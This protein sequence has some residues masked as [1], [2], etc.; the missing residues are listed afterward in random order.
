M[1][2]LIEKR[3][4]VSLPATIH[5]GDGQSPVDCTVTEISESAARFAVPNADFIPDMFTIT[6]AGDMNV[7]R[8]CTVL[9]RESGQVTVKITR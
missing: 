5:R 6:L 7:R 8:S 3:R 9:S 1:R 2:P 4:P